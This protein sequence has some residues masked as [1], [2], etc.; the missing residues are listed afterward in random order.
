MGANVSVSPKE[1]TTYSGT[2]DVTGECANSSKTTIEI[3]VIERPSVSLKTNT[4]GNAAILAGNTLALTAR[5]DG[6][7]SYSWSGPANFATTVQNPSIQNMQLAN[8]GFYYCTI[9]N[10]S[11]SAIGEIFVQVLNSSNRLGNAEN[12]NDLSL[13]VYPNPS[14]DVINLKVE[15]SLESPLQIQLI[16]ATGRSLQKWTSPE[17]A[18]IHQKQLNISN[19]QNGIYFILV[20]SEGGKGVKKVVKQ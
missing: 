11:C 5:P 8:M 14:D 3:T 4:T 7:V 18:K 1:T 16:D 10:G 6:M 15:L 19:F 12:M 20:E 9:N 13:N 17:S 2:C